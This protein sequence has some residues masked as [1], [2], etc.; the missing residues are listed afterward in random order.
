MGLVDPLEELTLDDLRRRTS[1]KWQAHGGDLLPLWVGEMDVRLAPQI[2]DALHRAIRDGDTGYTANRGYAEAVGAFA[3]ERWGWSSFPVTDARV[4]ADVMTAIM[5]VIKVSS[6]P[7]DAV[8]VTSPV[9][10]PFFSYIAHADRDVVEAPLTEAGRLD[11]EAIRQTL[12]ELRDDR[13]NALLLISNPHNPTG[14]VPTR[15]ELE[16][17]A[18]V[19]AEFGVRVL[20]DEIHAP[21]VLDGSVFTP[22]LTVDGASDAVAFVSA[23]KGWNLAGLKAALAVAGPDA[24]ADLRAVP[25]EID[26][27]PSH[28]GVMAHA[29]AFR[30]AGEW[31][32]LL[33]QGLDRKRGLLGALIAEQLPDVRW[34]PPEGTYL[35]WLDCRALKLPRSTTK[36]GFAVATDIYGPAKLFYDHG[37]ALNAGHIFGRGG[38]GYVRLNFATSEA[39]LTDALARMG[40]AVRALREPA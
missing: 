29:V 32:D 13:T 2:E 11:P 8:V 28:L 4:L 24:V 14:S 40:A 39:I 21:L 23:S 34:V 20:S 10:A 27:A 9:Y 35:A 36:S 38:D 7:G 31:L 17:I 22:Y 30:E 16:Q 12:R 18:A 19:A 25:A 33:L 5:E 15:H 3:A 26:Y 1:Q 6:A 37:V